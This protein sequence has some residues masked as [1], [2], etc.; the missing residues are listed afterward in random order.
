[1]SKYSQEELVN[2]LRRRDSRVLR[3]IYRQYYPV[4]LNLIVNNSGTEADAQDIFQEVLIVV[5]NKIK[6]KEEFHLDSSLKTYIYSVARLLWL[7][8][9]RRRNTEN[10]FRETNTYIDFDEPEPFQEKDLRL[11][12]YQ[13]AFMKLPPDCQE[14]LKF[15]NQGISQK[16][17]AERMGLRSENYIKKRKHYCKEYL[18]NRVKEDPDYEEERAGR[19]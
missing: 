8:S 13:R 17:I 19:A 16:E 10:N 6:A 2:G 3:Y 14:I 7:K 12:M 5:F 9:L 18:I 11:A 1:M 4:I 15:T